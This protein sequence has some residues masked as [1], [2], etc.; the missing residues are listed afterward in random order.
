MMC[1]I[2]IQKSTSMVT[3]LVFC[4]DHIRGCVHLIIPRF[5]KGPYAGK[6][7]CLQIGSG[8]R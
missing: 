2:A 8:L 1:A 6:E 5:F 3:K 4:K 7:E